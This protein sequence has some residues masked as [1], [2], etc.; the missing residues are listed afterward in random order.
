MALYYYMLAQGTAGRVAATFYLVPGAVAVLAWA[1]FGERLT[2]AAVLGFAIAS[3]GAFL[4][5]RKS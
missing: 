4:V 5:A 2:P 3:S 1:L